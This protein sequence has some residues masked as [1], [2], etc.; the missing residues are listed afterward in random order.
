MFKDFINQEIP[1]FSSLSEA[2]KELKIKEN[3]ENLSHNFYLYFLENLVLDKN[4]IHRDKL[5]EIL[6]NKEESELDDFFQELPNKYKNIYNEGMLHLQGKGDNLFYLNEYIDVE[7]NNFSNLYEYINH[8]YN[9]RISYLQNNNIQNNNIIKFDLSEWSRLIWHSQNKST[10]Y[11]STLYSLNIYILSKIDNLQGQYLS[12]FFDFSYSL[13]N[14]DNVHRYKYY[15]KQKQFDYFQDQCYDYLNNFKLNFKTP[16]NMKSSIFCI[17]KN[18]SQENSLDIVFCDEDITKEINF[19]N[20]QRDIEKFINY[21]I[22]KL[23]EIELQE[24]RKFK[25]FMHN[26]Y[27]KSLRLK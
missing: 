13:K 18:N 21:D 20:F 12:K 15:G 6:K 25:N 22:N 8:L 24:I 10:F 3:M 16:E 14:K 2:E 9:N 4:F 26:A 17:F 5:I 19:K 27:Q 1:Y 7:F 11:Y 23:K